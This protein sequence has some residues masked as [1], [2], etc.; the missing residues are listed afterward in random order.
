VGGLVGFLNAPL[1]RKWVVGLTGLGLVLYSIL[2]LVGNL[3]IFGNAAK[4]N[5]Y[6]H[7]LH[8]SELLIVAEVFL[9]AAF[10]FHIL[11]ALAFTVDGR[12]A[13]GTG[14][15]V[16]RSKRPD[17]GNFD[18]LSHRLMIVTGILVLGFL[19][20]HV[21]QFRAQ[22]EALQTGPGGLHGAVVRTLSVPLWGVIYLVGSLLVGWHLYRGFQSAWRSLG[23]HHARYTPWLNRLGIL[24]S[25]V[26]GLGF[27]AVAA[28]G[29]AQKGG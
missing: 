11:L 9:Y 4:F 29:L 17:R 24:V 25:V 28:W 19:I 26:V 20:V 6:A 18:L 27:A 13:R 1:V 5:D 23:I 7:A 3:L 8:Q 22:N 21:W 12:A 15:K 14:Y 2:H 10:A 16:M